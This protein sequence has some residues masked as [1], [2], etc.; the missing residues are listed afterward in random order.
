MFL[1]L[2]LFFSFVHELFA[3]L[4]AQAGKRDDIH[5]ISRSH[6]VEHEDDRQSSGIVRR[7]VSQK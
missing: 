3:W 7:V 5:E 1:P 4:V 2:L 6:G